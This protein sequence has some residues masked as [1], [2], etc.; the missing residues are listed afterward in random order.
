MGALKNS[1]A[2]SKAEGQVLTVAFDELV[3]GGCTEET[4]LVGDA[5]RVQ[6]QLSVI[7]CLQEGGSGPPTSPC[8]QLQAWPSDQKYLGP[9]AGGMIDI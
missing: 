9:G 3:V 4:S 1:F 2:V 8:W 7:A 5:V 6:A